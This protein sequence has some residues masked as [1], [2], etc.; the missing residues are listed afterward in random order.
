M[1]HLRSQDV[2]TD[3]VREPGAK[4]ATIKRLIDTTDGADRF[5]LS[6]FEVMPNGSTP[7]H[8]HEWEHEI[9]ILEGSMTLQLPQE[10]RDVK[11]NAGDV[12]FIPRNEPHGFIT[13]SDETCRFLVVAPTERPPIRN[14]FLTEEPYQYEETAGHRR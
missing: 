10:K 11:L 14:Y 1:K 13:G 2:P 5:V 7:P 9:F 6:L 12:I 3:I 4:Q 8:Y